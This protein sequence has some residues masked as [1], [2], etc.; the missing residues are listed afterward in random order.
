MMCL[1]FWWCVVNAAAMCEDCRWSQA[2]QAVPESLPDETRDVA[3]GMEMYTPLRWQHNDHMYFLAKGFGLRIR[4]SAASMPQDDCSDLGTWV[5]EEPCDSSKSH[6]L[7]IHQIDMA[8]G[9]EQQAMQWASSLTN[10]TAF[11]I[12]AD[13]QQLI[14]HHPN[15]RP[16]FQLFGSYC[17]EAVWA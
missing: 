4:Y 6:W 10:F 3:Q 17:A 15:S 12:S 9:S 5:R 16:A 14:F 13:S 11:S 1:W 7:A 2:W 8:Y